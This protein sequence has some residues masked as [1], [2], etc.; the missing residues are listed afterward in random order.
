MVFDPNR[1]GSGIEHWG[2]Q[3]RI[4]ARVLKIFAGFL[5]I[6]AR[7]LKIFAGVLKIFAKVL[8]IFAGVLKIFARVLKIFAGVCNGTH[9]IG[10]EVGA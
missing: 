10:E 9:T 7:V 3:S 8:K 6:F 5:K 2:L 1:M 4:F